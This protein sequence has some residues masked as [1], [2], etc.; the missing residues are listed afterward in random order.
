[1]VH[2]PSNDAGALEAFVSIITGPPG[3]R[4]E[5]LVPTISS[6]I[7]LLWG[8]RVRHILVCMFFVGMFFVGTRFVGA[9]LVS[10]C[11]QGPLVLWWHLITPWCVGHVDAHGRPCGALLPEPSGAA[12]AG[13]TVCDAARCVGA[14]CQCWCARVSTHPWYQHRQG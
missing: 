13:N 8:D 3:P 2:A 11:F 6:P 9:L 4:P 1:M 14:T 12:G 7:L 10:P 5:Q